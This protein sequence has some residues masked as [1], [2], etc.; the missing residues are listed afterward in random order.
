MYKWEKYVRRWL[1]IHPPGQSRNEA[2]YKSFLNTVL[3]LPYKAAARSISAT[4]LQKNNVRNYEIGYIPEKLSIADG[5][6]RIVMITCGSDLNGT[7]D[8]A[9]L[10]YEIVAHSESGATYSML[11]GSIGTFIPRDKHPERREQW[12]YRH[13]AFNSVWPVFKE[14]IKAKYY[15][16]TDGSSMKIFIK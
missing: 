1:K 4:E 5:N 10:D 7:E 8:D 11:H 12:T 3:G 6:G 15:R 16:D 14:I 9:R 2:K 13:G